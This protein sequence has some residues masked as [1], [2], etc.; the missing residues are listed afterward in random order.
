MLLEKEVLGVNLHVPVQVKSPQSHVWRQLGIENHSTSI[1]NN[2]PQ[3]G[4]YNSDLSNSVIWIKDRMW[5]I[6]AVPYKTCNPT[7]DGATD[8]LP[9]ICYEWPLCHAIW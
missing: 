8:A 7:G 4:N 2:I 1:Y 5:I 9:H 6:V 3:L